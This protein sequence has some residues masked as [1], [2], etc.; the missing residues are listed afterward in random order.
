M[1]CYFVDIYT[2]TCAVRVEYPKIVYYYTEL[3]SIFSY[4]IL[5]H[6]LLSLNMYVM[7]RLPT[8]IY[9]SLQTKMP[10]CSVCCKHIAIGVNLLA[11]SVA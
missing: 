9:Y 6:L 5:L 11:D 2:C 1:E 10:L 7:H 8:C 4:N 3:L